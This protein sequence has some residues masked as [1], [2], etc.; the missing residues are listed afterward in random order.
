MGQVFWKFLVAFWAALIL[1]GTLV[2][3]VNEVSR[4]ADDEPR[5]VWIGPQLRLVLGSAQLMVDSG[6]IQLLGDVLQRWEDD[7]MSRDKILLLNDKGKDYLQREVPPNWAE[8]LKDQPDYK[9][10]DKSGQS[11]FLLAVPRHEFLL[12]WLRSGRGMLANKP[13]APHLPESPDFDDKGPP[14]PM[15]WYGGEN[16]YA[17]ASSLVSSGIFTGCY[18]V[19][20]LICQFMV[21]LVLCIASATI[22]TSLRV[23]GL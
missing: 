9:V 7:P 13:A 12:D 6:G 14:P 10:E 21:G 15:Q 20:Q 4:A 18:F 22:K 23:I 16:C 2:W 17:Y 11:W 1:A 19:H 8:L 3:T 5:P